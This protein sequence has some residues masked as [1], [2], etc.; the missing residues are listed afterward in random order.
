ME[1]S[2]RSPRKGLSWTNKENTIPGP[3]HHPTYD[4]STGDTRF[5]WTSNLLATGTYNLDYDFHFAEATLHRE[6]QTHSRDGRKISAPADLEAVK[7]N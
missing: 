4:E 3:F 7:I 1:R 6:S 2:R 5:E